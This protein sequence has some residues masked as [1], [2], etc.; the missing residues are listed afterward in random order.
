[1]KR[2]SKIEEIIKQNLKFEHYEI[3]DVSESHRGHSGF[4]EG[5]E[6]H[7]NILIVSDDFKNLNRVSRQRV[8]NQLL[9]DEFKNGLHAVSYCLF[10]KD[11]Y[12]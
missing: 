5:Q 9:L 6:T 1:M 10:T 11:E 4:V 12:K 3:D 8:L 7:L 2:K